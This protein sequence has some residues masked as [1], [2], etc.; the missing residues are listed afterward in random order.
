MDIRLILSGLRAE[1]DHINRAIVALEAL[2]GKVRPA[3]AIRTA[4]RRAHSAP[5]RR[6]SAA[7]RKRI[8]DLLKQRWAERKRKGKTTL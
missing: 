8:S 1:R 7:A 5:K 4:A 3:P 6:L 2:G